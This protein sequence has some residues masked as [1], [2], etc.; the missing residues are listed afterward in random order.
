MA[1]QT[2]LQEAVLRAISPLVDG[3]LNQLRDE[4]AREV[5]AAIE[6]S[7]AGSDS[8]T[9]LL[10]KAL[11]A[12]HAGSGQREILRT[13]LDHAAGLCGRTALFI[14]KSGSVQGWQARGFDNSDDIKDFQLDSSSPLV[15]QS[16]EQR[17]AAI[18]TTAKMDG[19]F[20]EKFGAPANGECLLLPL[21]LKERVA[22]LLYADA[23]T[24]TA[25]LVAAPALQVLLLATG[26]WL[27]V[28]A[29]RKSLSAP[30]A[31]GA[32]VPRTEQMS[33]AAAEPPAAVEPVAE[34][35]VATPTKSAE[36]ETQVVE[37]PLAVA[38]A[39][40]AAGA[41]PATPSTPSGLSSEE[42]EIHR[43]AQRFARLLVD[44]IKL[45]NQAKVEE[46]RKNHDL[47]DRL[48]EDIEKSR[49]TYEKRYGTSA[50]ASGEYFFQELIRS[51]AQ[52]DVSIFGTN[53]RR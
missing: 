42:A 44:E 41:S 49:S 36:P 27:E 15:E 23:G 12:V 35:T 16:L 38:V 29:L 4:L 46:G 37:A 6:Q 24:G 18:G 39:A 51:L 2:P 33:V 52:D 19:S 8:A 9:D 26:S 32:E 45:Y 22:A 48:K 34:M 13:L 53:F 17:T 11:T 50:A 7:G 1:E 25:T 43:K 30:P 20:A 28:L 47:Y 14:V 10:H 3:R 5:V 31:A 21:M 40:S